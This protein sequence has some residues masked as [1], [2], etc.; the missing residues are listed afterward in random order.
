MSAAK[1]DIKR[2]KAMG[3]DDPF[4]GYVQELGYPDEGRVITDSLD[5]DRL[6]DH[7]SQIDANDI[8]IQSDYPVMAH[9]SGLK[10]RIT[11]R[12][13]A[14]YEVERICNVIYGSN[15][16]TQL[17][18]G[19]DI[20]YRYT[21]VKKV[22]DEY[23]GMTPV[24]KRNFRIN[25]TGCWSNGDDNGIQVTAR[26]IAS[27]PPRL[28]SLGIEQDII[29]NLYPLQGMVCVCGPTGSGKTT[30]LAAVLVELIV[31]ADSHRKIVTYE[32]PIEFLYDDLPRA[33]ALMAQHEIPRHLPSFARGVRNA[34]RRAPEI[35]LV[36]ETRDA[37]TAAAS[38]EASQTGH[39]LYTTVHANSVAHTL[40]RLANLFPPDQRMTKVF[41]FAEMLRLV[42][43]Q[44]LFK[45]IGGGRIACREFL[46][47]DQD[48][49]DQLRSATSLREAEHM[50]AKLVERKGQTLM[51][52]VTKAH[53]AGLIS[54]E[55]LQ[56]VERENKSSVVEDLGMDF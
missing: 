38:I 42:V 44:R 3:M 55:D 35:L 40:S 8:T 46:A 41:E 32:A 11:K 7:C 47:F 4:P 51:S 39:A 5:L 52:A 53:A 45:R 19:E 9:V 37:E 29:D 31:D 16:V 17:R 33:S 12:P 1:P 36:G 22:P 43:V 27:T 28:E 26:A 21:V 25:I 50:L 23:G 24:S 2:F 10:V 6:F 15:G 18:K 56:Q 14:L 34:L 13:L 49:R 48:V 20:D 54:D 30:L